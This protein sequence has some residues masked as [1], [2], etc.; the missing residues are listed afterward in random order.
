LLTS[1]L[2]Y[3]EN[4]VK[5]LVSTAK[6]AKN[7]A[8]AGEGGSSFRQHNKAFNWQVDNVFNWIP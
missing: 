1:L 8:W 5:A 7:D 3:G 4:H 2:Q 6:S